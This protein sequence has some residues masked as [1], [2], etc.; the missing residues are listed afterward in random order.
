MNGRVGMAVKEPELEKVLQMINRTSSTKDKID[1]Y[2]SVYTSRRNQGWMSGKLSTVTPTKVMLSCGVS[3]SEPIFR[4]RPHCLKKL[5]GPQEEGLCNTTASIQCN[6]C[7]DS[8]P[9]GAYD[10]LFR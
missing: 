7:S 1:G 5:P 3:R 6:D 8:S 4:S 9:E 10:H 2:Y